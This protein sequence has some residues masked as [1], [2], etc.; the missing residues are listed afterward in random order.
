MNMNKTFSGV[1]KT[2]WTQAMRMIAFSI[3][4]HV[5]PV[6]SEIA[7]QQWQWWQSCLF[8]NV[9]KVGVLFGKPSQIIRFMERYDI[10]FC[11]GS[12]I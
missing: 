2:A 3:D 11:T 5:M 1:I 10:A 12:N 7:L 9:V 4:L 6:C 8:F